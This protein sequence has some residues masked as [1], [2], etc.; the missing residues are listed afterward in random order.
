MSRFE[1]KWHHRFHS[2]KVSE[3]QFWD[4]H[5]GYLSREV[6]QEFKRLEKEKKGAKT[7]E[8]HH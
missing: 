6:R 3:Y 1:S 5:E 8:L 4:E 7:S 2:S